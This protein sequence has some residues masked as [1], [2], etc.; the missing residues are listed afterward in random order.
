MGSKTLAKAQK[1]FLRDRQVEIKRKM[2]P[3]DDDKE[4]GIMN[5]QAAKSSNILLSISIPTYNRGMLLVALTRSIFTS[6]PKTLSG[7]I[8]VIISDNHSTDGTG[9]FLNEAFYNNPEVQI[10]RPEHHLHTAEENLCFAISKCR[11]EYVWTLGD[12]DAIE[13]DTFAILGDMLNEGKFDFLVY[14]SRSVTYDGHLKKVAQVECMAPL[15]DIPLLD[16]VRKSGFWFILAGF[17]MSVFRRSDANV[18]EFQSILSVGRIYAHVVWLISCFHDKRFA[19][20]NRPLVAYRENRYVSEKTDHWETVSKRENTFY[21]GL[22]ST[23]FLRLIDCLVNRGIIERSFL[24]EVIDRN[25]HNR[26][27]FIDEILG[28]FL[29]ALKR[30]VVKGDVSITDA[31]VSYFFEW[32]M[33]LYSNNI[34]LMSLFEELENGKI[35]SGLTLPHIVARMESILQDRN[36]HFWFEHLHKFNA[37]G[38]G[39][40]RHGN[41]WFAI[42]V[43]QINQVAPLLENL[44]FRNHMN[45]LGVADSEA[46]LL[47]WS[48]AQPVPTLSLHTTEHALA[49]PESAMAAPTTFMDTRTI[50]SLIAQK[51]LWKFREWYRLVRALNKVARRSLLSSIG[52]R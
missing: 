37:Y 15:L 20:V 4:G 51:Q 34:V 27:Y 31:E 5:I 2:K 12:D 29:R 21:G 41:D 39:I 45:L 23:G 32:A 49:A 10:H 24:I 17:S 40:Y 50:A 38:Y 33:E 16:F 36:R 28:N 30:D 44:D 25:P 48:R 19:F 1:S 47:E 26:Y 22:W 52:I 46:E 6:L 42:R 9:R 7:K 18:K 3:N 14:N 43:D 35:R 8:E 13:R 11:G